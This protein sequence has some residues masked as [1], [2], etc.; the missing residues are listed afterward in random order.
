MQTLGANVACAL[1]LWTWLS[2]SISQSVAK[3]TSYADLFVLASSWS[4]PGRTYRNSCNKRRSL[5]SE[6]WVGH[7]KAHSVPS[8]L[9]SAGLLERSESHKV[10][11]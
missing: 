5:S 9:V 7:R 1:A 4:G 10:T 11:Y 6:D 8:E 3:I 2:A